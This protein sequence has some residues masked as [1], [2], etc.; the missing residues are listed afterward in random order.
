MPNCRRVFENRVIVVVPFVNQWLSWKWINDVVVTT[1]SMLV[2]NN[3]P[4]TEFRR[5]HAAVALH[6]I[7]Y[8]FTMLSQGYNFHDH[9]HVEPCVSTPT[10]P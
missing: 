2:S 10:F 4:L 9:K 3:T 7:S 1:V 5:F 8:T 6:T